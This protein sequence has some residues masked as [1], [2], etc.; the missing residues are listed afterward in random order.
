MKQIQ[1]D[2]TFKNYADIIRQEENIQ[3]I[4]LTNYDLE[5][6]DVD[7]LND[8]VN[9]GLKRIIFK[10]EYNE[11]E[12]YYYLMGKKG[13]MTN[14]V[15]SIL[16]ATLFQLEIY[17]HV[18]PLATNYNQLERLLELATA[19]E[20]N[21]VVLGDCSKY[22]ENQRLTFDQKEIIRKICESSIQYSNLIET[23]DNY[24]EG[25]SSHK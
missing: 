15:K 18:T 17:I 1:Q 10:F 24:I 8:L 16:N 9:L 11:P 5:Y 13:T 4:T 20:I 6:M 21:K 3:T 14:V 19:L 12:S 2:K 22:L 25:Y 7:T 23:E